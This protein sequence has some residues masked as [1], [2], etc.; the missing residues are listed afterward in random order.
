MFIVNKI[1]IINKIYAIN[2]VKGVK[3]YDKLIEKFIKLKIEKLSKLKKL[4][5]GKLFKS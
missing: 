1:L 5:G 4:K 2:K 3:D